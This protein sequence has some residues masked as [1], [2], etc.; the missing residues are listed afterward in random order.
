MNSQNNR[1]HGKMIKYSNTDIYPQI[2]DRVRLINEDEVL[3]VEDVIDSPEKQA[4]WGLEEE[5]FG[6]MHLGGRYGRAFTPMTEYL[7][8]EFVSR[9]K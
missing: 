8:V 1:A 6:I 2:G 4:F 3:V 7:D 5:D 9:E